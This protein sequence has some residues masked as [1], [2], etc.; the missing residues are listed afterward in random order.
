MGFLKFIG[1]PAGIGKS[2]STSSDCFESSKVSSFDKDALSPANTRVEETSLTGASM[3]GASS[4]GASSIGASMT[5][6]SSIG[7][8]SIGASS[9]GASSI[10]AS[11]TG[12]SSIG[13]SSIGASMTAV[14]ALTFDDARRIKQLFVSSTSSS[15]TIIWVSLMTISKLFDENFTPSINTRGIIDVCAIMRA[16]LV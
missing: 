14:G 11:M 9:I 13:A 2:M 10:G 12:A 7:A 6:A 15:S 3:S 16:I 4:I 8:S 1:S 5:G